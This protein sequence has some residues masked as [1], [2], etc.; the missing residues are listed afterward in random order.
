M[1]SIIAI[2]VLKSIT[3]YLTTAYMKSH[4]G[5]VDIQGAPYWYGREDRDEICVSDVK[6]GDVSQLDT[7]KKLIKIKLEKKLSKIVQYAIHSNKRF[8]NLK[9]D[10]E[11]F[12]NSIIND[13]KLKWF[14]GENGYYK[15]I[16]VDEDKHMIFARMCVKKDNFIN[17][18]KKRI[19]ELSKDLTIYKADKNFNEL[20]GKNQNLNN[21]DEEDKDFKELDNF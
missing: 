13:K 9:Q 2:A 5:S 10:E 11:A 19:K 17:Y 20:D 15:N 16:K 6:K 1:L 18:E 14:V 12:L 4:F 3:C 8:S 7:E 21:N